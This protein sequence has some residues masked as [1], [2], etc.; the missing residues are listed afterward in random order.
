MEQTVEKSKEKFSK[1]IGN[2]TYQVTVHFAE[3]TTRTFADG[4]KTL[5]KNECNEELK[6]IHTAP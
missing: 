1:K 5:I 3:N 4:V 6:N 2:T